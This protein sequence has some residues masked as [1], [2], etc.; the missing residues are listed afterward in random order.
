M[1]NDTIA[2]PL[3]P[4]IKEFNEITAAILGEIYKTHPLPKTIDPAEIAKMLGHSLDDKLPSG[5]TFRDMFT[6]TLVWLAEQD[7]INRNG[8]LAPYRCHLTVRS[9]AGL[10]MGVGAELASMTSGD[11]ASRSDAKM[12]MSELVGSFFGSFIGAAVKTFTGGG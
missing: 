11:D 12:K 7:L 10:R 3:P 6:H 9:F 2:A 5:R 1:N 4:N 8:A